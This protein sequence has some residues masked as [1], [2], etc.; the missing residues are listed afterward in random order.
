MR[1]GKVISKLLDKRVITQKV[2]EKMLKLFVKECF[3]KLIES[4]GR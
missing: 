1:F 3:V 2:Y 4:E